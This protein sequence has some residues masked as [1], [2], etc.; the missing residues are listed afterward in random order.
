M[1]IPALLWGWLSGHGIWYPV[2]LLSGM[3]MR[4]SNDLTVSELEQFHGEW[5]AGAIAMHVILSLS[6][7]LAVGLVL[8]RVPAIPGPGAWGGLVMPILWTAT[9][10]GLMGIVNPVLQK[11]IDWPWFVAS[12]FVFGLVASIVV[13]RSEM[14]H[15]PPAGRGQD[16]MAAYET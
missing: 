1:P 8:P 2:N 7:G 14:V 9:S 15:I 13:V 10:Y 12:Q 16:D 5:L 11:Q 3:L 4:H 6:F